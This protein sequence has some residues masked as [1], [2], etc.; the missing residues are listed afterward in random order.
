MTLKATMLVRMWWVFFILWLKRLL[1]KQDDLS[2]VPAL[3]KCFY[4]LLGHNKVKLIKTHWSSHINKR[5]QRCSLRSSN[6]LSKSKMLRRLKIS[7]NYHKALYWIWV[8]GSTKTNLKTQSVEGC[9]RITWTI[10]NDQALSRVRSRWTTGLWTWTSWAAKNPNGLVG[11]SLKKS[12][13][14]QKRQWLSPWW[15]KRQ[16]NRFLIRWR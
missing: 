11:R 7:L 6:W 16:D 14:W 5:S 12:I 1:A 13:N 15:L 10:G 3:T 8:V 2:L 4:Y 9:W